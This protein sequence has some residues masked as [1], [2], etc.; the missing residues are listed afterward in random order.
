M[1]QPGLR[2][3]NEPSGDAVAEERDHAQSDR[4]LGEQAALDDLVGRK[5]LAGAAVAPVVGARLAPR[6]TSAPNLVARVAQRHSCILDGWSP[7]E[8]GPPLRYP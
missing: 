2:D 3:D 8:I 6:R 7:P 5:E 4:A 1:G